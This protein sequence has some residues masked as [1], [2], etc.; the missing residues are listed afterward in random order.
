MVEV[1]WPEFQWRPRGSLPINSNDDLQQ[2]NNMILLFAWVIVTARRSVRLQLEKRIYPSRRMGALTVNCPLA[3][4][5]EHILC[6]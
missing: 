2:E 6:T 5:T 1:D 3:N 4:F